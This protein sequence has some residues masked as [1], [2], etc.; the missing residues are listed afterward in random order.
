MEIYNPAAGRLIGA[1]PASATETRRA[2]EAAHEAFPM[3]RALLAK[4]GAAIIR[5][6]AD[7]MLS[8]LRPC[9]VTRALQGKPLAE[10]RGETRRRRCVSMAR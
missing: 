8:S 1:V 2:V 7:L 6:M 9:G 10:A 3:W 5:R 4:D